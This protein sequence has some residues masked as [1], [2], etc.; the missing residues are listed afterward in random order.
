MF[1]EKRLTID[2]IRIRPDISF[3]ENG[4]W[5]FVE[6]EYGCGRKNNIFRHRETI[7]KVANVRVI[8]IN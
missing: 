6:I 5:N 1:I 2:G 3:F 4:K 8:Y 7:A